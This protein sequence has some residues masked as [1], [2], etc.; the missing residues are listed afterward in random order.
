VFPAVAGPSVGSLEQYV[1][2]GA[3]ASDDVNLAD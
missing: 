2:L 3:L 1:D